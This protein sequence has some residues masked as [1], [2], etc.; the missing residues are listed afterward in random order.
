MVRWFVTEI[1]FMDLSMMVYFTLRRKFSLKLSQI[2][3]C[4]VTK[5]CYFNYFVAQS[6]K[7]VTV[8]IWSSATFWGWEKKYFLSLAF[9]LVIVGDHIDQKVRIYFFIVELRPFSSRG[10]SKAGHSWRKRWWGWGLNFKVF[11]LKYATVAYHPFNVNE[12]TI[13]ILK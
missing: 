5:I 11:P 8:W 7:P 13:T 1:S 3:Y 9:I 4:K 2:N 6:R 10:P 12:L